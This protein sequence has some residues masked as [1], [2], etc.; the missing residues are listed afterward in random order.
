MD[1]DGEHEEEDAGQERKRV[2]LSA[3][4]VGRG[5]GRIVSSDGEEKARSCK[6]SVMGQGKCSKRKQADHLEDED[7]ILEYS[8]PLIVNLLQMHLHF[9]V[10]SRFSR[11]PPLFLNTIHVCPPSFPPSPSYPSSSSPSP[12]KA[13]M[14]SNS[15]DR[16]MKNP[17][18]RIGSSIRGIAARSRHSLSSHRRASYSNL[19]RRGEQAVPA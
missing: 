12:G 4:P 2:K 17:S 13:A 11:V 19:S 6:S 8:Y 5:K 1:V 14:T 7:A 18:E 3:G 10:L 16:I 9:R 15:P